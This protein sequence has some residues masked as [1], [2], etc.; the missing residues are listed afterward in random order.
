MGKWKELG[1]SLRGYLWRDRGDGDRI[2][3]VTCHGTP[4]NTLNQDSINKENKIERQARDQAQSSRICKPKPSQ[5]L[6]SNQTTINPHPQ[7][8]KPNFQNFQKHS[9]KP[10]PPV[11]TRYEIRIRT[12][13]NIHLRQPTRPDKLYAYIDEFR[14][15][16]RVL[17]LIL[18]GRAR[19]WICWY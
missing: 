17:G 8:K 13:H 18:G 1:V 19:I 9:H 7:P 16:L 14:L 10:N 11:Q 4:V 3:D 5:H 12:P 15:E 2:D 6:T